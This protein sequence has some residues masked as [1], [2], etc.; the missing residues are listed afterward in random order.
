MP[1]LAA[2]YGAAAGVIASTFVSGL[3]LMFATPKS[4]ILSLHEYFLKQRQASRRSKLA[5]GAFLANAV[6]GALFLPFLANSDSPW[7]FVACIL[8]AMAWVSLCA[9]AKL[10]AGGGELQL[11][12]PS[13][14]QSSNVDSDEPRCL[15]CGYSFF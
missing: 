5:I 11:K 8:W 4:R 14:S 9:Y 6:L 3:V 12:C 10:M 1:L 13:C 15:A 7:A 2:L